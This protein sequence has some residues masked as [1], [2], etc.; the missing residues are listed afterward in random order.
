MNLDNITKG[1]KKFSKK[2]LD[3]L[4]NAYQNQWEKELA[5]IK[6]LPFDEAGYIIDN[7]H[8]WNIH[9]TGEVS[10]ETSRKVAELLCIVEKLHCS[11]NWG[12]SNVWRELFYL[13]PLMEKYIPYILKDMRKDFRLMPNEYLHGHEC[14][15]LIHYQKKIMVRCIYLVCEKLRKEEAIK[16]YDLILTNK[17]YY[18]EG[19]K[20]I[21]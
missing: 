9:L 7:L 8:F 18:P 14:N 11:D 10:E 6:G 12:D 15:K 19:V 4:G 16:E 17:G 13:T 21:E 5:L 20:V 3:I 2:E 1:N